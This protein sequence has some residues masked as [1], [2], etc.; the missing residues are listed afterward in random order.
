M[1][2]PIAVVVYSEPTTGN[3]KKKRLFT[4]QQLQEVRDCKDPEV[5]LQKCVIIE[6]NM[7]GEEL[8]T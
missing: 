7:V 2:K 8:N 4:E 5:Q 6:A 1:T 3:L